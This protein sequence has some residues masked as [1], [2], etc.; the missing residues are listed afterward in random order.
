MARLHEYQGKQLLAQHGFSVPRGGP[1]DSESTA[2]DVAASIGGEVVVKIQ[3]WT[4]GRAGIGGIAFAKSP[5]EAA[6]LSPSSFPLTT[7]PTGTC[8]TTPGFSRMVSTKCSSRRRP[9][10]CGCPR[11][12]RSVPGGRRGRRIP[13]RSTPTTRRR[14]RAFPHRSPLFSVDRSIRRNRQGV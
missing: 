4:T 6:A 12:W 9:R 11:L 1:A 2:R 13:Q 7:S 3:A 5:Q 10:I 14:R 8:R